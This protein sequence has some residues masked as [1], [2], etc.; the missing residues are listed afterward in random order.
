LT[1]HNVGEAVTFDQK[2]LDGV[3]TAT[4]TIFEPFVKKDIQF[5]G[6]PCPTC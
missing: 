4:S 3:S 5:T 1:R 6:V 2:T